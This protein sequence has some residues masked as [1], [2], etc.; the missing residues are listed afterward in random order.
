MYG[1]GAI[2]GV[3]EAAI[4]NMIAAREQNGAFKD[5]FDFCQRVDL[6]KINRRV[7]EALIK[8]GAFDTFGQHRATLIASLNNALQQA[9]QTAHNQ[10][11]GQHD[12][13]AM[14]T[15]T[16]TLQ[17]IEAAPWSEEIQLQG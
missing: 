14:D 5:L 13:L 2:K 12:L 8:A 7:L 4:E 9:E 11:Y 10:T 6:R 1:L 17:Y 15:S 3:G 16:T